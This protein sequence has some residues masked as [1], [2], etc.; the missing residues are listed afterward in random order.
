MD[1]S[2]GVGQLNLQPQ[3]LMLTAHE[4]IIKFSGKNT[5]KSELIASC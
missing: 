3:V 4:W 5:S 1:P 2:M